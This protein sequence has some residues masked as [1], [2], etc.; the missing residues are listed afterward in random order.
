MT[1]PAAPIVL[2]ANYPAGI[3]YQGGARIAAFRGQPG[4]AAGPEDW[5]AS[6]SKLPRVLLPPGAADHTGVSYLPDGTS[7]RQAV[8]DDPDVWLGPERGPMPPGETGLLVKL[9]DAGERLPVHCHPDRAFAR[10]HLGSVFGKTEGWLIVDAEP[11]AMVWL[12]LREAVPAA[13]WRSWIDKQETGHLLSSLNPI[14]VAPGDVLYVP[15][16]VPHAIGPGIMLIELQEPTSFSVTAEYARFGLGEEYVT[17]GLGWDVAID[18]FDLSAWQGERLSVPRP[19]P[20]EVARAGGSVLE[21]LFATEAEPFFQAY[22]ARCNGELRLGDP[23]F[24]VVIVTDGAGRLLYDGG[25]VDI[26]AG[27]T[28]A[29]PHGAGALNLAGDVSAIVCRPAQTLPSC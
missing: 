2:P 6:V 15:A 27:Q 25:S 16:G 8:S 13:T 18:A 11:G 5:I 17:L 14:E 23:G 4:A 28:L 26:E 29:V 24:A 21:A 3:Y 12:G 1:A 10:R 9:L 19:H 20:R 7:L 22:R